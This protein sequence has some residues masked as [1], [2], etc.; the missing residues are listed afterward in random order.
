MTDYSRQQIVKV[1]S[2]PPGQLADRFHLVSLPQLIFNSPTLRHFLFQAQIGGSHLPCALG[3][4]DIQAQTG[5]EG[6][7]GIVRG[8][9][10][11]H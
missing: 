4:I 8:E 6:A 3:Q 9:C 1:M 2:D 11:R 7:G 5:R 10:Y